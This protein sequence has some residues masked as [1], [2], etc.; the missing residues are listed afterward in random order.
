MPSSAFCLYA[1]PPFISVFLRLLVEGGSEVA[2]VC[3]FLRS[4]SHDKGA[5]GEPWR[6]GGGPGKARAAVGEAISVQWW[7]GAL[8]TLGTAECGR[9]SQA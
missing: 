3:S 1:L 4:V 8:Q 9:V 5:A 2:S 7:G 6:V